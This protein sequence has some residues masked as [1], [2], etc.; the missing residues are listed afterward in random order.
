MPSNAVRVQKAP[1]PAVTAAGRYEITAFM[2][3]PFVV[4]R[5]AA[6]S[7]T[8]GNTPGMGAFRDVERRKVISTNLP[9]IYLP[10]VFLA[11]GFLLARL[12][13]AAF[14]AAGLARDWLNATAVFTR[15]L[16]AGA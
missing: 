10:A 11:D 6:R 1:R 9:A 14:R 15:A 16:N 4:G 3:V 8:G 12:P 13:S 2:V 5:L 7:R